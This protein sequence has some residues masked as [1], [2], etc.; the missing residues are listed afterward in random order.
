MELMQRF[1]EMS[2]Y[3]I[4][5]GI[6]SLLQLQ[7]EEMERRTLDPFFTLGW[8]ELHRRNG[9][10]KALSLLVEA[11]QAHRE[12]DGL[13]LDPYFVEAWPRLL[14]RHGTALALRL[15]IDAL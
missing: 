9:T 12:V 6:V 7:R 1:Q 5:A 13:T 8:S 14:Q 10:E 2:D 4:L 15:V 11:I 3:E